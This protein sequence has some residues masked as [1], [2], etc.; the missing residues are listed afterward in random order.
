MGRS[1]VFI[2]Y[3]GTDKNSATA[4]LKGKTFLPSGSWRDWLGKGVYF[5]EFDPHQAF[6]ITV[7]RRKIS[8]QDVVVLESLIRTNNFIDLLT[9]ED[10]DFIEIFSKKLSDKLT[11][12]ESKIGKW[13]HKEGYVLDAL[14]QIHPYEM[15]RAAYQIPRKYTYAQLDYLTVQIQICVKNPRCIQ[16]E[17]I[18]EVD[19]YA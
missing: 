3:H 19:S 5:F 12:M 16:P 9:D 7:A 11:E 2:G 10:R 17:S 1:S 14:Y 6:M 18:K 15:V 4:I 13:K 8:C